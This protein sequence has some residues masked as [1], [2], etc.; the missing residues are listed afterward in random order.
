MLELFFLDGSL[1][2]GCPLNTATNSTV[3]ANAIS[4]GDE[5]VCTV[6]ATDGEDESSA[7]SDS[8]VSPTTCFATECEFSIPLAVDEGLD[9]LNESGADWIAVDQT[10]QIHGAIVSD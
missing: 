4:G 3:P 9:F 5:W 8:A 2:S 7:Y 1:W 10:G 6:I